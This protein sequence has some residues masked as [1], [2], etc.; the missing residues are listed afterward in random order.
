MFF[1]FARFSLAG[2]FALS[3]AAHAGGPPVH[4]AQ[5]WVAGGLR[6]AC[7]GYSKSRNLASIRGIVFRGARAEQDYRKP[8]C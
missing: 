3:A 1:T 6:G 2:F 4:T 5:L 7:S 8:T